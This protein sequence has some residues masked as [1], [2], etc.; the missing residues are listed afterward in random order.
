L[1]VSPG[2]VIPDRETA[3]S[4]T[5]SRR[6]P[7]TTKGRTNP[8]RGARAIV[9]R[10]A[11]VYVAAISSGLAFSVAWLV[12]ET[13]ASALLGWAAAVL[14]VLALRARRVYLAA[15]CCGLVVHAVGFYW[16]LGTVSR[17]GGFGP[18]V[19]AFVFTLFVAS[20]ALQFLLLAWIH[21]N[22]A[23]GLDVFA[24]RT[25][26]AAVLSELVMVRVFHWHFGHTQV[27]FTPFAQ[28]ADIGGALLVSFVMFWI[29]EAAVRWVVFQERRPALVI[30]AVVFAA[31]LA[32]G[33]VMMGYF[34]A[35]AGAKQE[36]LLVQGDPGLALKQDLDSTMQNLGRIFALTQA[37]AREDTLVVWPESSVPAYIPADVG[38]A[39]KNHCLPWL[40]NGSAFLVGGYAYRKERELF[41]TAFAVY[42]DGTVPSPYFKQ[43]L[44]PFGEYVPG[45]SLLPW[46]TRLS[47]TAGAFTPGTETKVFPYPMRR[48][49]GRE[50]TLH[51]APL[52]CYEDTV[53][54]LAR[55]AT[56]RGAEI[57]V[58]LTYDNWFGRTAAPFQHHLI[59]IFR[60]IENRR[61][62][63]RATST[64][65]TAVVDP[66]GKTI[67]RIPPFSE[68]RIR[69]NVVPLTY[70]S[71]YTAYLGELPWWL[72]FVVTAGSMLASRWRRRR[73]GQFV[74]KMGLL[75]G[76]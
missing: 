35:P 49:D 40:G 68:G 17:F 76:P 50:Y 44:I 46:L 7:A 13:I 2:S 67:A 4:P 1:N 23:G 66:L 41:N 21:H 45:A 8:A 30:P 61:Y 71:I 53:T 20:G 75:A 54:E 18:V 74:P 38:S 65:Y 19:S 62:L 3:I 9:W 72:L 70:Q 6:R 59:A 48:R 27:A 5:R 32:Y 28:L 15:Y 37:A 11:L 63:I 58:N 24:L 16:V 57:L 26:I 73:R 14:L 51:V 52:I 10:R 60:A 36:V 33:Q 22:L 69:V 43:I 25:P 39:L 64:G 29:A 12:A 56:R 47:A 42:P 31:S 55:E 34:E